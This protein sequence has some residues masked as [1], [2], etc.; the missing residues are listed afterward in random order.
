MYA[1]FVHSWNVGALFVVNPRVTSFHLFSRICIV[2]SES[3]P[4]CNSNISTTDWGIREL[5]YAEF[6]CAV[7][8]SGQYPPSMQ[9]SEGERNL[10]ETSNVENSKVSHGIEQATSVAILQVR[11]EMNGIMITCETQFIEPS[12]KFHYTN[13]TNQPDYLF[14]WNTTLNVH[15]KFFL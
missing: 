10:S 11:V 9:W 13:A 2:L 8:F 12:R 4:V 5:E 6:R 1:P 14:R 7:N 3:D 15:C